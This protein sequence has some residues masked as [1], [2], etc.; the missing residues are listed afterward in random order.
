MTTKVDELGRLIENVPTLFHRL[1]AAAEQVHGQGRL[2]GARRGVLRSLY[3]AGPQTVP[4][5]ARARPVS[6][7]HIQTLVNPLVEEGLVRMEPN[8]AHRRSPLL[9]ITERGR[10]RLEEMLRR[11][12]DLLATLQLRASLRDLERAN[13]VLEE[14]A[15][16]FA[17]R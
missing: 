13:T 17:P 15:D 10:E 4:Q 16:R 9:V 6:R 11:E 12:R 1:R 3:L 5:L 14:L 7:Q 2:T 8:P